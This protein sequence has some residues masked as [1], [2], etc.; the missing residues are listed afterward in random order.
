MD[1]VVKKQLKSLRKLRS[2]ARPNSEIAAHGNDL[3]WLREA[4]QANIS[5]WVGELQDVDLDA[6]PHP[7]PPVA[8]D[9]KERL[10]KM[11]KKYMDH[12]ARDARHVE[13]K[14]LLRDAHEELGGEVAPEPALAAVPIPQA[15]PMAAGPA[16]ALH[17][18]H[19]A[20]RIAMRDRLTPLYPEAWLLN[21]DEHLMEKWEPM[22]WSVQDL[23]AVSEALDRRVHMGG[24][25]P[26]ESV[27]RWPSL[28]DSYEVIPACGKYKKKEDCIWPCAFKSGNRDKTKM[29]RPARKTA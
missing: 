25:E 26:P 16:D 29:C 11:L 3:E 19:V 27:G 4:S 24:R 8:P 23:K 9:I 17:A 12:E 28:T 20:A 5:K 10:K 14:R 6:L 1:P 21:A 18:A 15:P 7:P 13:L 2:C 22:N